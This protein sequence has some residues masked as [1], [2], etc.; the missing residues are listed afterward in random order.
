M[1]W[2]AFVSYVVIGVPSTYM[3]GFTFG[4]GVYGIILSF[5]CSLVVAALLFL[6]FFLKSTK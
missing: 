4:M 3:L 2:I 6:C 5:S 1:L